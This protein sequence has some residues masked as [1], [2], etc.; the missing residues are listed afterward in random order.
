MILENVAKRKQLTWAMG[1]H[2]EAGLLIRGVCWLRRKAV[3]GLGSTEG[4]GVVCR[5][6]GLG[7]LRGK[8]ILEDEDADP[9][10]CLV[11]ACVPGTN[12]L[13]LGLRAF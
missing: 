12:V 1:G 11:E 3:K 10:T 9:K 13:F 7:L 5:N 6:G 4:W 2:I 8:F